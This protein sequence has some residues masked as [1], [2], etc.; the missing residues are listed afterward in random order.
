MI[1]LREIRSC[2]CENIHVEY[3]TVIFF[4]RFRSDGCGYE[5]TEGTYIKLGRKQTTHA[6]A[7]CLAQF[8]KITD[9]YDKLSDYI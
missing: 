4:F 2:Q 1:D 9:D 6:G 3:N 5:P 7:Y 8:A